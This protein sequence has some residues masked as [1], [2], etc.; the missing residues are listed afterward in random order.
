MNT[1]IDN[2]TLLTTLS[3][4]FVGRELGLDMSSFI[5]TPDTA[6]VSF[7]GR[8]IT[9]R[10]TGTLWRAGQRKSEKPVS[11]KWYVGSSNQ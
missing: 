4:S 3:K 5:S 8:L 1:S 6:W 9:K 11:K 2:E 10:G 7:A